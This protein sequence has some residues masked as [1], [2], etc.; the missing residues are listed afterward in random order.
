MSNLNIRDEISAGAFRTTAWHRLGYVDPR[1]EPLTIAD[2]FDPAK[3]DL[4]SEADVAP[5]T[6]PGFGDL[7]DHRAAVVRWDDGREKVVGVVGKDH[8]QYGPREGFSMLQEVLEEN[9]LEVEAAVSLRGHRTVCLTTRLPEEFVVDTGGLDDPQMLYAG[10]SM[11][12][13]GNSAVQI[14]LWP[15]S[16][17]CL[18]TQA[19]ALSWAKQ[20]KRIHRIHH[21]ARLH[22]NLNQA[23]VALQNGGRDYMVEHTAGSTLLARTP[24]TEAAWDEVLNLL[25]PEPKQG[26]PVYIKDQV[27]IKRDTLDGIY[28]G[29]VVDGTQSMNKRVTG[30]AFGAFS[31]FTEYVDHYRPTTD[32]DGANRALAIME[33]VYVSDKTKVFSQMMRLAAKHHGFDGSQDG[34]RQAVAKVAA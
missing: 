13:D 15:L 31:A 6:A 1:N 5:L 16:I 8:V 33:D 20:H 7:E 23:R 2:V 28:R 14:G 30:T 25:V 26:A 29:R 11:G 32:E 21:R 12:L 34:I 3:G 4:P 10:I 9:A 17:V 22:A 27:G 19:V 18:N 24:F